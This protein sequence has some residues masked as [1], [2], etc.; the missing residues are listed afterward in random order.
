MELSPG[1]LLLAVAVLAPQLL[2]VVRRPRTPVPQVRVAGPLV[3]IERLGQA[4]CLVL[5][6]VSAS[7]GSLG[8]SLLA[9]MLPLVAYYGLW[10]RYVL[11][12]RDV[13][14]LYAPIAGVPVPMALLPVGVFLA[15][16]FWLADPWVALG[17]CVLAVGHVPVSLIVA[18]AVRTAS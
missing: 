15:A 11:K 16:A 1:G 13:A 6:A 10:G 12:G 3:A 7:A 18:R 17:A 2:L 4:L 5:P 8:A 14:D 9:V